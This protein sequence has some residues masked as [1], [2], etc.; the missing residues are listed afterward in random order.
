MK[1]VK[2]QGTMTDALESRFKKDLNYYWKDELKLT[3]SNLTDT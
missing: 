1:D 2:K 3:T